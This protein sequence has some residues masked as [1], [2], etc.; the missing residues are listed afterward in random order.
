MTAKTV[1]NI[2]IKDNMDY[3][4]AIEMFKKLNNYESPTAYINIRTS[5]KMKMIKEEINLKE[6]KKHDYCFGR[7]YSVDH[8]NTELVPDDTVLL[9]NNDDTE[10]Y[11]FKIYLSYDYEPDRYITK[12]KID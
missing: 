9:I 1:I 10:G 4:N 11:I 6:V 12:L 8:Y 2:K 7:A 3:L 5:I